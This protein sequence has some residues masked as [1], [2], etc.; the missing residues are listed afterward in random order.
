VADS[1]TGGYLTPSSSAPTDDDA[2]VDLLQTVIVGI[3]G[4]SGMLVRPRWQPEPANLPDYGTNWASLGITERRSNAYPFVEHE[5]PGNGTDTLVNN[6]T[7]KLETSFYGPLASTN[8]TYLRDGLAIAQNREQLYLA[9]I[10]LLVVPTDIIA[11][12]SLLKERWLF[13]VDM[14]VWF[15]REIRR[16]YPVLNLLSAAGVVVGNGAG[17]GNL[18]VPFD[19]H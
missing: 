11:L 15:V 14:P 18:T 16:T 4:L 13:R 7:F 19:A 9:G 3:T 2:L 12:P 10:S 5:S 1:S 6:E 17:T 8:A